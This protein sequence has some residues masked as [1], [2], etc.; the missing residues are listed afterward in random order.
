MKRTWFRWTAGAAAAVALL[1][2][3]LLLSRDL[4]LRLA[5]ERAVTRHTGFALEVQ[6]L[7]T[8][9]TA[10]V[11]RLAGVRVRYPGDLGGGT[12]LEAP[13]IELEYDPALARQGRWRLR[14]LRVHVRE[15]NLVRTTA[16]KTVATRLLE[17]LNP[18]PPPR[19]APS[20]RPALPS[21]QKA[22]ASV[23]ASPQPSSPSASRPTGPV[24]EGVDRL[25]YSVDAIQYRDDVQ[26]RN[27]WRRELKWKDREQ[28]G[29]HSIQDALNWAAAAFLEVIQIPPAPYH[30]AAR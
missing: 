6:R 14:A 4:L 10:P 3:A 27:S 2:V 9:L 12:L 21:G 18:K 7:Q 23:P 1:V 25:V 16:D 22:P 20:T 8:R 17:T 19:P 29:L 30:P 26:P 5:L 28:P 24:F 15:L 11:A 13:V